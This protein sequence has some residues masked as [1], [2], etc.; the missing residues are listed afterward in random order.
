MF[1]FQSRNPTSGSCNRQQARPVSCISARI[2]NSFGILIASLAVCFMLA[3]LGAAIKASVSSCVLSSLTGFVIQAYVHHFSFFLAVGCWYEMFP[4]CLIPLPE[5]FQSALSHLFSKTV[6]LI[7]CSWFTN[8][9]VKNTCIPHHM[10]E[11]KNLL[12]LAGYLYPPQ[13]FCYPW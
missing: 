12:F 4:F 8:H 13:A 1:G 5:S 3:V 6:V 9:S 2:S 11:T 7:L 10:I